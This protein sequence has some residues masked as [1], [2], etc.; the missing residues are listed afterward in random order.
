MVRKQLKVQAWQGA[1]WKTTVSGQPD[2]PAI[3]Q[4]QI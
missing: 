1:A 4:A 3:N 2:L